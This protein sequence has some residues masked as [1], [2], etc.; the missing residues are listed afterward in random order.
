MKFL[1]NKF[2]DCAGRFIRAF[3][4]RLRPD[5]LA[6]KNRELCGIKRQKSASLFP[7]F[8][9]LALP[10]PCC[11]AWSQANVSSAA[12]SLTSSSSQ[13]SLSVWKREAMKP[14]ERKEK[15]SFLD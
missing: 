12:T 10:L 6:G 2:R 15:N 5:F 11:V 1:F 14:W 4:F 13:C 7:S 8:F 3:C 9:A